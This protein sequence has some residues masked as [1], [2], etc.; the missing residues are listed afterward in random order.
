MHDEN[1]I[2]RPEPPFPAQR[3]GEPPGVEARMDPKPQYE[4]KAYRPAGKLKDKVALITGGDSGIGRSVAT[5]FA[6]EG[7]DV[8]IVCL[9]EEQQDANESLQAIEAAGRKGMLRTGD[10]SDFSFCREVVQAVLERFGKLNILVN[11]AA[12]QNLAEK[13]IRVNCVAPGPVWTPLNPAERSEQETREFGAGVPFRRPAQPEEIAP[14][15][16]YFASSA[17]SGYVTGETITLLG[18][19]VTAGS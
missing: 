12:F 9:P 4:G 16:V 18:G 5:L 11:N 8:A 6:R 2:D 19:G 15:F 7:A 17:D 14:A 13:G 10:V 3:T 1:R